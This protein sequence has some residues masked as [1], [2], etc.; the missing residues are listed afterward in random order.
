MQNVKN[1][2][3]IFS[4]ISSSSFGIHESSYLYNCASAFSSEIENQY[5]P[6]VLYWQSISELLLLPLLYKVVHYT[7]TLLL[8]QDKLLGPKK[9]VSLSIEYISILVCSVIYLQKGNRSC[10]H[11]LLHQYH[12]CVVIPPH[13]SHFIIFSIYTSPIVKSGW[14]VRAH[15]S[16]VLAAVVPT[17]IYERFLM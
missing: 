10:H 3:K 1:Y 9:S 12:C 15:E 17:Y 7:W 11:H 6:P 16:L 5:I 8:W 2:T 4:V 14:V 13:H